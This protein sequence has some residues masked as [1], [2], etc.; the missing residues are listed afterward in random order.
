MP[1]TGGWFEHQNPLQFYFS[2]H[3]GSDFSQVR[4]VRIYEQEPGG[5]FRP[6]PAWVG[7]GMVGPPGL[8]PGTYRL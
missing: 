1:L 5:A 6:L 4:I 3:G 7:R 8:E 2:R